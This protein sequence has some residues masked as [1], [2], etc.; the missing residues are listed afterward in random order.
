MTSFC[1]V[2]FPRQMEGGLKAKKVNM[3]K[4]NNWQ[5]QRERFL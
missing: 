2:F 1:D 3:T 5:T 4:T